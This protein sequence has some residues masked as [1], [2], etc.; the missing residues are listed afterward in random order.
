MP[1]IR[2]T[3][4]RLKVLELLRKGQTETE[5]APQLSVSRETIVR[6]VRW[7][8]EYIAYDF[9]L[10]TNEIMQSLHARIDNMEDRDLIAFLGKLIPHK[11][12]AHT[13]EETHEIK[14]VHIDLNVFSDDE[15]SILDK[16]ARILD[17]KS[18]GKSS[19]IH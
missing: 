17:G 4:R 11:I 6:D 12:E 13:L 9:T 15:K 7:L 5:I 8:K 10:I 1:Q 14:E 2:Q 3:E 18:K 19:A 16:A